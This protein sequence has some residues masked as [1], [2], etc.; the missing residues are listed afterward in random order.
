MKITTIALILLFTMLLPHVCIA[1]SHE[2]GFGISV[3]N[4][5][6]NL[7][8]D[9]GINLYYDYSPINFLV[10]R[11][12]ISGF[13]FDNELSTSTRD[14]Y[15]DDFYLNRESLSEKPS[16]YD[17][18]YNFS[19]EESILFKTTRGKFEPFV[20]FGIGYHILGNSGS[21]LSFDETK[22]YALGFNIRGGFK[23]PIA[24]KLFTSIEAKYTYTNYSNDIESYRIKLG[25]G[26]LV[27]QRYTTKEISN[28]NRLV[29]H[30]GLT[31][32]L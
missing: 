30:A 20:G 25:G 14:T 8:S 2:V 5:N 19:Y 22:I 24:P 10:I 16:N 7:N 4:V 1:A 18:C 31:I 23:Y 9:F 26:A 21:L 29:L 13:Y 27:V 28:L 12:E 32:E 17:H 3:L 15:W 11:S 6:G